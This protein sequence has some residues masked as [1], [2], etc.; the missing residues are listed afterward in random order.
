MKVVEENSPGFFSIVDCGQWVEGPNCSCNAASKQLY[1]IKFDKVHF[2]HWVLW[3]NVRLVKGESNLSAQKSI[4]HLKYVF[5]IGADHLV[6]RL[7]SVL[8]WCPLSVL[9][10]GWRLACSTQPSVTICHDCSQSETRLLN[11]DWLPWQPITT[12]PALPMS[13]KKKKYSACIIIVQ[14]D[15]LIIFFFKILFERDYTMREVTHSRIAELVQDEHLWLKS[16]EMF[17][18]K[19]MIDGFAR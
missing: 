7:T 9:S 2:A 18:L 6:Q 8:P 14:V 19:K 12:F 16:I 10:K 1:T 15:I 5:W 4:L 13:V 11:S 3:R 17:F